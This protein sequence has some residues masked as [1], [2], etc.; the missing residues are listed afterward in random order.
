MNMNPDQFQQQYPAPGNPYIPSDP[1]ALRVGFGKRLG[2]GAIDFVII[3]IIAIIVGSVAGAALLATFGHSMT[4]GTETQGMDENMAG[5][6]TIIF[7]YVLAW[8]FTG[9]VYSLVE[10]FTGASPAKHILGIVAA[11]E[12]RRQGDIALYAKRW[13]IKSSP[14]LISIIS[15]VTGVTALSWL[16]NLLGLAIFVG[17]F[18]V[19]GEKKQALHDMLAKTAIFHKEDVVEAGSVTAGTTV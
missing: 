17:C 1:Y 7:T 18:F 3:G 2:A 9:I 16:G 13:L 19:L 4:A 15:V 5:V 12:D 14:S 8:S 10:L 11:H 6:M